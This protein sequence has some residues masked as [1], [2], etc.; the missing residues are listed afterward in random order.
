MDSQIIITI[1]NQTTSPIQLPKT[2]N[3]I[4]LD[5][6]L[7]SKITQNI[8]NQADFTTLNF[9]LHNENTN[10]GPIS[11]AMDLRS[12]AD[13]F[14]IDPD[15][16][17]HLAFLENPLKLPQ[18]NINSE[19][20]YPWLDKEDPQRH[21]TDMEILKLK[22]KLDN[23][24]LDKEQKEDFYTMIHKNRDVFSMWDKIGTCLQ[25]Q[26]HLKL[27]DETPFFVRPYPIREEQKENNKIYSFRVCTDFRVLND[28]LVHINHAF[29]LVRYCIDAISKSNCQV[30]SALN[31]CD[32]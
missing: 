24:I 21:M 32:A 14:H 3:Y 20:P 2:F 17:P 22:V 10:R 8:N 1:T 6:W 5:V 25:I 16:H 19:D 28:R 11:S 4:Y 31:L 30:M 23:S 29:P 26:V 13:E 9:L 15:D 27:R 12:F 18:N 7:I